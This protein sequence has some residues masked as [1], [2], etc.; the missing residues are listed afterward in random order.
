[1]TRPWWSDRRSRPERYE[2]CVRAGGQRVLLAGERGVGKTTLV[3]QFRD[4]V[5]D[6][7]P[8]PLVVTGTCEPGT[9]PPY[10][11]F[12]QAFDSFPPD[13]RP[14]ELTRTLAPAGPDEG[15]RRRRSL[16]AD[17][18]D[19]IEVV[20]RDRPVVL[21]RVAARQGQADRARECWQ[22]ALSNLRAVETFPAILTLLR[23]WVA[24]ERDRDNA[25]RVE[26]LHARV[27]ATLAEAPPPT[28][29]QHR[30]WVESPDEGEP[31]RGD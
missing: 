14:P 21:G 20:T 8:E 10:E 30:E 11:P 23:A 6:R 17:I 16:F 26:Q 28:A 25:G 4:R 5:R 15:S 24:F 27:R 9:Q 1:M 7:E 31:E 3:G 18:H 19:H 12:R 13:S 2:D 29:R 22:A